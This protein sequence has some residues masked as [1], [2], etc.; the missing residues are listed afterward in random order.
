[1]LPDNVQ[2]RRAEPAFRREAQATWKEVG[3]G[4]G[5]ENCSPVGSLG[6]SMRLTNSQSLPVSCLLCAEGS[7]CIRTPVICTH[8]PPHNSLQASLGALKPEGRDG[9][10]FRSLS[11]LA[12][13]RMAP[14][15]LCSGLSWLHRSDLPN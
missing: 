9:A 5:F 12:A 8:H 4:A 14:A 2:L 7:A 3:F 6:V 1:M 10:E 11:S 15:V 13:P